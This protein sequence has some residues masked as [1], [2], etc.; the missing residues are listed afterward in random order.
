MS[1]NLQPLL[2][3]M[4][5]ALS[6]LGAWGSRPLGLHPALGPCFKVWGVLSL[7]INREGNLLCH[8]IITGSA[9]LS[10]R[11]RREIVELWAHQASLGLLVNLADRVPQAPQAPHL[12][13][14]AITFCLTYSVS[15]L[16]SL[17]TEDIK[18]CQERSAL[19]FE[20]ETTR[21]TLIYLWFLHNL[22]YSTFTQ[23]RWTSKEKK[24]KKNKHHFG[25]VFS[26]LEKK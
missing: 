26:I 2:F 16:A 10:V 8:A 23:E 13:V 7:E 1:A 25:F 18:R 15:L 4:S 14:R 24:K 19:C 11:G 3:Q 21:S 22:A 6:F 9:F 20:L 17:P 12:Q 5:L